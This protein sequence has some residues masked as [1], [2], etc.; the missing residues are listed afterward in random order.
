MAVTLWIDL[1]KI[2]ENSGHWFKGAMFGESVSIS[3]EVYKTLLKSG[4]PR[5][6]TD[7]IYSILR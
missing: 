2:I 6:D 4:L 5:T 3:D 7:R 1:I